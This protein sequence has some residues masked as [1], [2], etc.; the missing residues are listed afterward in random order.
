MET[1]LKPASTCFILETF[2]ISMNCGKPVLAA[3]KSLAGIWS[4]VAQVTIDDYGNLRD[5]TDTAAFTL[6]MDQW[7]VDV[8]GCNCSQA[9][10]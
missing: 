5:G 2:S 7:P 4:V 8:I 1:L 10:R 9:P 3:A 6:Q